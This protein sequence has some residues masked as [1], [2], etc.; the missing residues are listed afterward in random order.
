MKGC[1]EDVPYGTSSEGCFV[2]GGLR[3]TPPTNFSCYFFE[4]KHFFSKS[5]ARLQ[6][7][8]DNFQKVKTLKITFV[9]VRKINI[10]KGPRIFLKTFKNVTFSCFSKKYR[11]KNQLLKGFTFFWK[12]INWKWC[13]LLTHKVDFQKK[14]KHEKMYIPL[15]EN[16]IVWYFPENKKCCY[17]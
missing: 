7:I 5:Q 6:S 1:S 2:L 10:L 13:V 16:N 17:S 12:K 11:R 9:K 15:T 14:I 3:H 4:E 8:L